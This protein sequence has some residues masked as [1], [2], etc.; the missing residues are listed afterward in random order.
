MNKLMLLLLVETIKPIPVSDNVVKLDAVAMIT[1]VSS[2][3]KILVNVFYF[4]EFCF[5]YGSFLLNM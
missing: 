3:L 1:N 4:L 2:N 5:L